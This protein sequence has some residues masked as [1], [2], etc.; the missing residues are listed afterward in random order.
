MRLA[1]DGSVEENE[2]FLRPNA[3]LAVVVVT[4][5]DDCS[6]SNGTLLDPMSMDPLLGPP[7]PLRCFGAG[8]QCSPDDP[9][10]I[11]EKT[12]CGP[13]ADSEY[14]YPVTE[15]VNFL[16]GLKEETD[17]PVFFAVIGGVTDSVFVDMNLMSGFPEVMPACVA[18]AGG[19]G[20]GSAAPA[21]RLAA[22]AEAFGEDHGR[23][24]SLCENDLEATL[25]DIAA[26]LN[27]SLQ[28]TC[29]TG[30]IFDSDP[31]EPGYQPECQVIESDPRRDDASE[32]FSCASRNNEPPC[33]NTEEL[34]DECSDTLTMPTHLSL[35][36]VR[37][38]P[39]QPGTVVAMACDVEQT[40][41][42]YV[43]TSYYGCSATRVPSGAGS[44]GWGLALLLGGM[45]WLLRRRRAQLSH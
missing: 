44:A 32:I 40:T 5:G 13:R 26:T 29:L 24:G 28:G 39:P 18:N 34:P 15:Y 19:P 3:A 37:A 35:S 6:L 8:V 36:I 41:T 16:E 27:R 9:F 1:L 42:G 14:V 7:G 10:S 20:S 38:Q 25:G 11:G 45:C 4:D 23:F 22:V 21:I 17:Q 33:W 2:G 31:V 30:A 43:K 12:D